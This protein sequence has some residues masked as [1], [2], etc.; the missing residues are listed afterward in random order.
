MITSSLAA[1]PVLTPGPALASA[2]S[3]AVWFAVAIG[4]VVVILLLAAFWWGSRRV[5]RRRRSVGDPTQAAGRP[6]SDSWT[7]PEH[8]RDLGDS[9]R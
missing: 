9:Q 6:G 7:T 4:A 8:D 3:N 1:A 2:G 5:A